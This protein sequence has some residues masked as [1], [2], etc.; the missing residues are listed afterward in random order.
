MEGICTPPG[1]T[2]GRGTRHPPSMQS[3]TPTHPISSEIPFKVEEEQ[4]IDRIPEISQSFEREVVI[5]YFIFLPSPPASPPPSGDLSTEN[6]VLV[7][8]T[9]R[10]PVLAKVR[11]TPPQ[12]TLDEGREIAVA[13]TEHLHST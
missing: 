11:W 2:G 6:G 4:Y 3:R 9:Y 8:C 5:V 7:I 12:W 1:W 13:A 10:Q